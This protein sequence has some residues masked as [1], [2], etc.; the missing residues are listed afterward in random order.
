MY[1]LQNANEIIFFNYNIV[2]NLRKNP[3]ISDDIRYTN[4]V[5]SKKK[6]NLIKDYK[7]NNNSKDNDDELTRYQIVKKRET[8]LSLQK[9]Q[10][11]KVD[12][13]LD[14]LYDKNINSIRRYDCS[15]T[16]NDFFPNYSNINGTKCISNQKI[17]KQNQNPLL[18]SLPILYKQKITN[19]I[20][21]KVNQFFPYINDIHGSNPRSKK[22]KMNDYSKIYCIKYIKRKD[23]V[24][25]NK[26][27]NKV[28]IPALT[29]VNFSKKK[30]K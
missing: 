22:K 8:D 4:Q 13:L 30:V 16:K 20:I 2:R 14:N 23:E 11:K 10:R 28:N 3:I 15:R 26:K 5:Y 25:E 12:I 29:I 18:K 17:K 27:K 6:N 21:E 19:N 24:V 9:I 1:E 7:L